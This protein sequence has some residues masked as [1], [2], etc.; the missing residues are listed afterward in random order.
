MFPKKMIAKMCGKEQEVYIVGAKRQKRGPN[1]QT[2]P[3]TFYIWYTMLH[4]L[5]LYTPSSPWNLVSSLGLNLVGFW[6]NSCTRGEL[7]LKLYLPVLVC[8]ICSKVAFLALNIHE[9]KKWTVTQIVILFIGLSTLSSTTSAPCPDS[10]H[11]I[12]SSRA[13]R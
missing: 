6:K 5:D 4:A 8:N 3:K 9:L 7:P 13:V 1:K 2:I 12:M 10:W 11:S